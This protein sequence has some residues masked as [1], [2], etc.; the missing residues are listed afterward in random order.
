MIQLTKLTLIA[1]MVAPV[2]A[3]P[4]DDAPEP[5]AEAIEADTSFS[6][7]FYMLVD[8]TFTNQ[9]FFRGLLQESRGLIVQPTIEIGFDVY[10]ADDWSLSAYAGVW[11]SFHDQRTYAVSTNDFTST[12]YEL[13]YY[14]GVTLTT[15]RL[16][17]DVCYGVYTS[18]S[19]AFGQTDEV[20]LTLSWD[21]SG[22]LDEL[23]L[24]PYAMLAIETG[25][26]QNDCGNE[27]GLFLGLGIEPGHTFETSPIGEVTLSIPIEA[28]FSL[29]DYYEGTSGDE[30]FGYLSAGVAAEV[31][32]PA[33]D[34]LGDW[35]W[36]IGIDCLLLGKTN[37]ALNNGDSTEWLLHSGISFEF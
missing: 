12:W 21:D 6:D 4:A 22:W 5:D 27:L 36:S 19:D 1:C 15:G 26:N 16:S 7:R 20:M 25:P 2:C 29:D 3:Q 31:P 14:A 33:P 24:S 10:E 32:L 17:T 13:D 23:T 35:T 18:P 11:S 8:L 30:F 34:G 37:E 9:Y 28:G